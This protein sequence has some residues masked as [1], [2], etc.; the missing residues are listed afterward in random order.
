M[1]SWSKKF[2]HPIVLKDGRTITTL[3]EARVFMLAL[4]ERHQLRPFW[5]YAAELLVEA[6]AR[7]DRGSVD[8]AA[9]QLSRALT[10]EGLL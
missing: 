5:Q 2:W 9:A 1:P 3:A 4:P 10:A 7:G 6:A 8:D